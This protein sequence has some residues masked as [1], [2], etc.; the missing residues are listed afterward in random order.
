LLTTTS[1]ALP[2]RA[3]LAD[4]FAAEALTPEE[5]TALL[6]G[7]A[8]GVAVET[9]PVVCACAGVRVDRITAAIA[10]GCHTLDAVSSATEAGSVCGSCRPEVARLIATHAKPEVR[11]AA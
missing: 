7:R 9:S 6:V 2:P 5:R 4:L 8:P 10:A 1:G 11:H 3:W